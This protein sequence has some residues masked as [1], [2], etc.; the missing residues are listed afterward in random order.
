MAAAL[1]L[2]AIPLLSSCSMMEEEYTDEEQPAVDVK[3]YINLSVTVSG[4]NEAATRAGGNKPA[5]GENGDGREA[6]F[7]R[8]NKVSGIT[9]ILYTADANGINTANNPQIDFVAYYPTSFVSREGQGSQFGDTKTDEAVYTTG[10]VEVT[11]TTFDPTKTYHAIIVA[12]KDL[13]GTITTSSKLNDVR[14]MVM[15]EDLHGYIG[16]GKTADAATDFIMSSEEDCV[17]SPSKAVV[18]KTDPQKVYYRYK[19]IR[20]ER[21]AARID[22]WAACSE[23]YKTKADNA[24]YETPGYEYIVSGSADRFVVTGVTPFN[25]NSY[26]FTNGGTYLIKQ[27]T[28]SVVAGFT[29]KYL[30]DE[31]EVIG[32]DTYKYVLDPTTTTK[33]SDGTFDYFKNRLP[34]DIKP[35]D[36]G[37]TT[38]KDNDF[39]RSMAILNATIGTNKGGIKD[40]EDDGKK[41]DNLVVY[42]PVENTLWSASVIYYYATGLAIEGDYYKDGKGTPDH[43]IYYGYLRHNGTLSGSYKAYKGSN[44]STTETT[45]SETAMEYGIVRNNIYRVYIS[46]ISK[47]VVTG[48][49]EITLQIEVKNWDVF[50]HAPIYM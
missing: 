37:T 12:N 22:F 5:S 34:I 11:S 47:D 38:L 25:L 10:D 36:A 29:V 4:G 39:Y 24:A 32:G 46:S 50:E 44:V 20:I 31:N 19:D 45:T 17:I 6:G 15:R 26:N 28:N 2:T 48:D 30:V 40:F 1:L 14:E 43:R 49:A 18:D 42:Y 7:E 13:T 41:G 35:A 23:G 33:G 3:Q 16:S 9:L 27:L 21:L 8:E